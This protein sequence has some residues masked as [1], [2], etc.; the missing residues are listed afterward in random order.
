VRI[1]ITNLGLSGGV[2]LV[3]PPPGW[4]I[5]LVFLHFHYYF[6]GHF[7]QVFLGHLSDESNNGRIPVAVKTIKG[8]VIILRIIVLNL[9]FKN[10]FNYIP[11]LCLIRS[12]CHYQLMNSTF[13]CIFTNCLTFLSYPNGS[14]MGIE[15]HNQNPQI[16]P[17][18]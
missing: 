9:N 5:S 13:F 1:I 14:P 15:G 18:W 7:G 6:A 10:T 3:R 11:L 4:S 8:I 12:L 17:Y 16:G 2:G